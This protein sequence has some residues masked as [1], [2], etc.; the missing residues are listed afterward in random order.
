[1]VPSVFASVCWSLQCLISALTHGGCGGHFFRLP[2]SVMLQGGRN[3]TNRYSWHL[4]GVL[5]VSRPHWVCPRTQRVYFPCLHCL[6]SRLLCQELGCMH[7]PGLNC[8]G[9]S[10]RVC[11]RGADSVGPAF[12]ALSRSKQLRPPGVMAS[13]V[14]A[15]Y[16]LPCLCRS[17]FWVYYRRTFS[18][19]C[20]PSRIPR[21]FG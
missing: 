7:F 15:I 2:C 16:C 18:G 21:S 10:T 14:A 9:S 11:L 17:V 20:P 12:C 19:G 4:W 6:G 1:M 8:S 5:T 13:A 3:T